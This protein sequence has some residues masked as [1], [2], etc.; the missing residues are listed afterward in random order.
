V[1]DRHAILLAFA[2]L[3]VGAAV[4]DLWRWLVALCLV[5]ALGLV[6]RALAGR[7]GWTREHH[8]ASP[9]A[10]A[11]PPA[12]LVAAAPP[13]PPATAPVVIQVGPVTIVV[14]QSVEGSTLPLVQLPAPLQAPGLPVSKDAPW[15]REPVAALPDP[16]GRNR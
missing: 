1:T 10:P 8:S 7:T 12:A 11:P 3:V 16:Q 13:A 2:V 4:L 14:P 9:R 6:L 15:T 5:A